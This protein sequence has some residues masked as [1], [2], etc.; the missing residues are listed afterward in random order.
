MH[1]SIYYLTMLRSH[2]CGELRADHANQTVT[3]CG[4][5]QSRRD[6]GGLIFLDLRDRYG[7]T[8]A[9]IPPEHKDVFAIAEK[10]RPEWVI[11]ATGFVSKRR[12]GA[13]RTDNPTGE[14]EVQV[15]DYTSELEYPFTLADL[16]DVLNVLESTALADVEDE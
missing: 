6:H 9:V 4:W 12:E 8:Q 7:F 1:L 10:I 11:Q 16:H 2:T 14:I 15:D 3:L 5:V 13:E